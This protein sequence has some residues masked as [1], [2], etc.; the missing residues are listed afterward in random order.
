MIRSLISNSIH[1][2]SSLKCI[3]TQIP[4]RNLAT[5]VVEEPKWPK[6]NVC[7]LP[8]TMKV[9]EGHIKL[10]SPTKRAG[11][12][13]KELNDEACRQHKS[14]VDD[15]SSGDLIEIVMKKRDSQKNEDKYKCIVIGKRNRSINSTFSCLSIISGQPIKLMFQTYQPDIKE[16]NLIQKAFIH[17]GEKRVRKSKLYYI[18]DTYQQYA[19]RFGSKNSTN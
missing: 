18:Y 12:L 3:A 16:I 15:F 10:K 9:T 1:N 17:N 14:K 5:K 4:V 2:Y 8:S 6:Y 13:L 19:S 11:S 7:S